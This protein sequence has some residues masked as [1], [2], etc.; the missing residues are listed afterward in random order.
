MSVY[1]YE[2]SDASGVR[3]RGFIE[4]PGVKEARTALVA[5]GVTPY[6]L[7]PAASAARLPAAARA[8]LYRELGALLVAGFPLERALGLLIDEEGADLRRAGLLASLR[9]RVRGGASLSGALEAACPGLPDFEI[10]TLDASGRTGAQGAALDRLAAHLDERRETDARLR[11]AL[12]YPCFVFCAGL[13]LASLMLF[14]VVPRAVALLERAGNGVPA[15]AAA[16]ASGGRTFLAAL[17]ALLGAGAAA[18]AFARWRGR[19][20]AAF[21]A[22]VE[23]LVFLIPVFGRLRARLWSLRFAQTMGM[24]LQAGETAV[25]ALPLAALSTGSAWIAGEGAAQADRVR[26]GASLSD[27][28]RAIPPVA[29]FLAEWIRIGESSGDLQGM[30]AQAAKRCRMAYDRALARLLGI[31]E[32]ALIL[33]VGLLVLAVALS[34]LAPMLDLA[35]HAAG[36]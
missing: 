33:L 25:A 34:V 24:M 29:P 2:G 21:A 18:A 9:D 1:S 36:A 19:R 6:R 4:A 32:P 8:D 13:A 12:S 16:M 30:L 17:F 10:A 15:S 26:N 20:D 35:L 7:S 3:A 14:G 5:R 28:V 31:V 27:A 11:A 22:R 23:R